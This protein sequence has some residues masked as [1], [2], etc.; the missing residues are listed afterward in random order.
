MKVNRG[1]KTIDISEEE[2][3]LLIEGDENRK[4]EMLELVK[5]ISRG[6]GAPMTKAIEDFFR[7]ASITHLQILLFALISGNPEMLGISQQLAEAENARQRI[8]ALEKAKNL[9]RKLN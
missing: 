9:S 3:K 4:D 7:R 8:E 5:D 2:M 6:M 1:T